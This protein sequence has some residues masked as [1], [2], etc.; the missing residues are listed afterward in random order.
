MRLLLSGEGSSDIGRCPDADPR[1]TTDFDPGPMAWLVDQIV[2][3]QIGSGS[4]A[5]GLAHGLSEARLNRVCKR[6]KPM[7]L[8][9]KKRRPET[10]YYYR[11]ARGLAKVALELGEALDEDVVSVLFRDADG[12]QSAGRGDWASKWQSMMDG[13]AVEG[14]ECGVPMIPKPKSEAWLLCALRPHQAYHNCATLE[15]ASG[16]DRAV[17][18]LKMQLATALGYRPTA[19]DLAELVRSRTV[20]AQRLRMPAFQA[21]RDRL[22]EAIASTETEL[23]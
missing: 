10:G 1:T 15:S 16:N 20:D 11:N 6:L 8:R 21:F 4:L 9:G 5:L 3:E 12:T 14:F 22:I 7:S 17:N 19:D 2:E 18:S 13:F 23:R